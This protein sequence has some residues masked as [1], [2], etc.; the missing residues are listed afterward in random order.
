MTGPAAALQK[1]VIAALEANAGVAAL[2]GD[3]IYDEPPQ[4]VAFPFVRLGRKDISPL[5][6]Q[7]R[8][9]TDILFSVEVHSRP[10]AGRVEAEAIAYAVQTALDD[11]DLTLDAWHLDWCEYVT[12]A[13]FVEADGQSYIATV[14]F[15]AAISAL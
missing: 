14:A 2:V 4:G 5:R 9:D 12:S 3:R 13:G 15:R 1:A 10:M 7:C 6:M 11:A 8:T